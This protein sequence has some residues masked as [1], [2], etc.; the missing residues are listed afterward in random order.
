MNEPRPNTISYRDLPASEP[1][2]PLKVEWEFYRRE[3]GRL[4]AEGNEG[5]HVLIKGEEI[6][7]IFDT[8]LEASTEGSRRYFGQHYLVH[9]IQA[10]ERVY[11]ST[12]W[13]RGWP[14]KLTQ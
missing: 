5:R 2:S 12:F 13:F 6:I 9:Q 4:L 3:V 11:R 14:R 1:D 8:H 7:G 10:E